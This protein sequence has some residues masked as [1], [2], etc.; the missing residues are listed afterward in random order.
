MA[1][2]SS[3]GVAASSRLYK[4]ASSSG[5]ASSLRSRASSSGGGNPSVAGCDTCLFSCQSE[6][7]VFRNSSFALGSFVCFVWCFVFSRFV[8]S[9]WCEIVF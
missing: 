3:F 1:S 9:L 8:Y 7:H 5:L 2:S 4:S 6:S